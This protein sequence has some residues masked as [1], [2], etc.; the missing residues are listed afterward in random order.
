MTLFLDFR[1]ASVGGQAIGPAVYESNG[2]DVNTLLP[3]RPDEIAWRFGGKDLLFVAHGFNVNRERG[4]YSIASLDAFLQ[5]QSPAIVVGVLWP[6][7]SWLPV[8]DYPFEGS[9]AIATGRLLA[10]WCNGPGNSAYTLSF[11][12]HSLGARVVLEALLHINRDCLSGEYALSRRIVDRITILSSVEDSVLKLAFTVG[13]PFADLLHDDH[14][15]FRTAL[16]YNGPP[17]SPALPPSV[18]AFPIPDVLPHYGHG[19]YLPA[20]P[21]AVPEIWPRAA[22]FMKQTFLNQPQRW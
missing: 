14:T 3:L 22:A 10:D 15:P 12:S 11:L 18:R 6:G 17:Q 13:D 20:N 5:L 4:V 1:S 9:V 8:V 7:D 2:P 19:D 16:G 21:P